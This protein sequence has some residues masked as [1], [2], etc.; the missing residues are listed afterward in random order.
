MFLFLGNDFS[1]SLHEA[2]SNMRKPPVEYI[3]YTLDDSGEL[4]L[5]PGSEKARE[6]LFDA[7]ESNYSLSPG[8]L[9]QKSDLDTFYYR[10]LLKCVSKIRLC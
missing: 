1:N 6:D 10:R 2:E 3:Y 5:L 9:V 4:A 8:Q 7:M